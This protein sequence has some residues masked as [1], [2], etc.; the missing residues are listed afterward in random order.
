MPRKRRSPPV[1]IGHT[2]ELITHPDTGKYPHPDAFRHELIRALEYACQMW[3]A[4]RPWTA[5]K[6]SDWTSLFRKRIDELVAKNRK[7]TRAAQ[8][9][10]GRLITT[11]R[12][13]REQKLIGPTDAQWPVDWKIRLL[14]YWEGVT[15]TVHDPELTR[16][17][18][19]VEETIRILAALTFDPR[20]ELLVWLSLGQNSGPV[21]RAK[22]GDLLL[23]AFDGTTPNQSTF[24]YGTLTL[25][26]GK[27]RKVRKVV[28]LTEDQRS[29]LDRALGEGGYLHDQEQRYSEGAV[30]NFVLFPSGYVVGRVG[31]LRG[32]DVPPI[33]LGEVDWSRSVTTSWLRKNFRT[34]E[35]RAGVQ[36]IA[37]RGTFRLPMVPSSRGKDAEAKRGFGDDLPPVEPADQRIIEHLRTRLPS[38]ALSY[39]QAVHDLRAPKRHSWRGP[40]TDLREALRE[41]LDHLAPDTEVTAQEGFRLEEG[42]KGPTMRQKV[43]FVLRQRGV[44]KTAMQT[45]ESAVDAVE[46][47]VGSFVRSVYT[48]S[49]ISAHTPTDRMEVIRVRDWVR[50]ALRELLNID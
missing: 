39:Q 42:A 31:L 50:A 28:D 43:R 16:P 12:W 45:P 35:D 44:S 46:L 37:G 33:R 19:T 36:H 18:H 5:I 49:S 4:D 24:G 22:R 6:E 27:S 13:L 47:T 3:G 40:A 15:N 26:V 11:V 20:L 38:A 8:I 10:V 21:S 23:T 17:R 29:V 34:A 2:I 48:R 30:R 41:T 25:H 9:T 32:K 7:A 14:R 1:T